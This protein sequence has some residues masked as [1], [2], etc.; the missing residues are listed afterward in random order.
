VS[1]P[2]A[3][4]TCFTLIER[5]NEII[6]SMRAEWIKSKPYMRTT[7]K[8]NHADI[9]AK[10][11]PVQSYEDWVQSIDVSFTPSIPDLIRNGIK[12][13]AQ[14]IIERNISNHTI[15]LFEIPELESV[16][17]SLPLYLFES[18]PATMYVWTG[19]WGKLDTNMVYSFIVYIYSR[20]S[21][22][23]LTA[24][25]GLGDAAKTMQVMEELNKDQPKNNITEYKNYI[26]QCLK[27]RI[28]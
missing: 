25:I 16:E 19:E 13:L 24:C 20:I 4:M 11:V 9:L 7:K 3:L 8:N 27:G 10:L 21:E 23:Y 18:D 12:E 17:V 14:T 1:Y 6:Q 5:Q 15:P 22:K 2:D 28:E 26:S